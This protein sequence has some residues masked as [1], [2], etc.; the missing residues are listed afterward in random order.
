MMKKVDSRYHKETQYRSIADKSFSFFIYLFT[1]SL[2]S[3]IKCVEYIWG[4]PLK[5]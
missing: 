3:D 4:T 1:Y 5:K 2:T